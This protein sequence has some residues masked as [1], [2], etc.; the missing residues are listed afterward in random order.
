MSKLKINK[1]FLANLTNKLQLFL[2]RHGIQF[3]NVKKS[4]TINGISITE[5]VNSKRSLHRA[6]LELKFE[7]ELIEL[8]DNLN[9]ADYF[10]DIGANVGT[11]SLYA[12]KKGINVMA[13]E[14]NFTNSF[15]LSKNIHLNDL[16]HKVHSF[17][18]GLS[19][20]V[21]IDSLI[22]HKQVEGGVSAASL[23][24]DN[25][26]SDQMQETFRESVLVYTL[27]EF[28]KLNRNY[29][30][31][32]KIDTDGNELSVLRGGSEIL[33]DIKVQ[34]LLIEIASLDE[35]DKI[36]KFLQELNF[37]LANKI[38]KSSDGKVFNFIFKK[39]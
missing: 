22:H 11:Y 25:F 29:P 20:Y 10:F 15:L 16:K 21:G 39:I 18:I 28:V 1:S 38:L 3:D 14:P 37:R 36:H 34:T 6:S 19:N 26:F 4:Q 2:I 30:S 32:I 12:G 27:D 17:K 9:P 33:R 8:I 13:F 23:H 31:L 35:E 24:G 7:P 5:F